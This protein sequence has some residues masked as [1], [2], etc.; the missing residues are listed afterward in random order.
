MIDDKAYDGVE[1]SLQAG[2]NLYF[3]GQ[4]LANKIRNPIVDQPSKGYENP[5]PRGSC[6]NNVVKDG[7]H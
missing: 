5:N 4:T 7:S 3:Q 2:P 1:R 6:I